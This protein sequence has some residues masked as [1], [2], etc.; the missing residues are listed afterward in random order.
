MRRVADRGCQNAGYA[1]WR[2]WQ[3]ASVPLE[4]APMGKC[5]VIVGGSWWARRS[6]DLLRTGEGVD[7]E[8]GRATVPAHEGRSDGTGPGRDSAGLGGNLRGRLMQQFTRR[9][10]LVFAVGVGEQ[11]IVADA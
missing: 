11:S 5:F 6:A 2:Q 4:E 7:D 9:R 10:D 3:F 1:H 8:H